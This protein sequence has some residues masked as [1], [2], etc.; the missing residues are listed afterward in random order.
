MGMR[1]RVRPSECRGVRMP[2]RGGETGL[3][4]RPGVLVSSQA[5]ATI[6]DHLAEM[7]EAGKNGLR[8]RRARR[9]CFGYGHLF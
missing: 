6:D 2:R 5:V 3:R 9:Q 7:R 8:A 1:R 4:Q